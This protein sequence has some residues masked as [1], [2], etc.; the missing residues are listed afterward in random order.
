VVVEFDG[1]ILNLRLVR[2][3]AARLNVGKIICFSF[4]LAEIHLI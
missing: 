1:L 2:E 4:D 3:Q